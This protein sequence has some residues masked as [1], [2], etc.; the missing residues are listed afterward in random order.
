MPGL[1]LRF[2]PDSITIDVAENDELPR[3]TAR[4]CRPAVLAGLTAPRAVRRIPSARG[5]HVRAA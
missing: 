1:G 3:V 5:P 4:A 2:A